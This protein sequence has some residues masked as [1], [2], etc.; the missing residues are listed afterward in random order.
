MNQTNNDMWQ[1]VARPARRFAVPGQT[2][3]LTA[4]VLVLGGCATAGTMIT[5]GQTHITVPRATDQAILSEAIDEAFNGLDLE[6]LKK[7]LALP[8]GTSAYL[9]VAS[10]FDLPPATLAYVRQRAAV[11]AGE[12]GLSLFEVERVVERPYPNSPTEVAY[13]RYPDTHARAYIS[14]AYAGVDEEITTGHQES[15]GSAVPDRV[16]RGR[17]K[18]TFAVGP[19]KTTFRGISEPLEGKS[20]YDIINGKFLQPIF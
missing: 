10:T 15:P 3:L 13:F 16:L 17:F 2:A 9:E 20:A 4:A 8:P 12:V 11:V 1:H 19:R 5:V 14:I 6:K 18:A 7:A